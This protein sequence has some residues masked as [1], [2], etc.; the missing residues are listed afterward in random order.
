[1]PLT[2]RLERRIRRDFPDPETAAEISRRLVGLPEA[3]GYSPDFF[4]QERCH[5]ALVLLAGGSVGRFDEAVE[6]ASQDWRD[7]LVA[8]DLAHQDWPARLRTELGPESP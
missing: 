6:L 8:A 3:M 1:M 5:A 2:S 7:L 4:A